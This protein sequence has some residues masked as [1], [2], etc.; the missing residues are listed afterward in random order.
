LAPGRPY[1]VS[2]DIN[3]RPALWDDQETA[4]AT[5]LALARGADIVLVGL[6]EAQ[7]LWGDA[8][9]TPTDVR[10]LLPDP[11]ILVVKDAAKA[12]SAFTGNDTVTVPAL[13]VNVVEPVGAGDAFAAG[14]L[15]G[16]LR[17]EPPSRALRLGHLTA[18]AALQVTSDHGPLP[19]ASVIASLLAAPPELWCSTRLPLHPSGTTADPG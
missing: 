15:T 11:H 12:A 13:S 2:F 3:Y 17:D 7:A 8:L 16:L 18:A 9:K 14:F 10:N 1:R 4:A 5:L 6:D 19:P